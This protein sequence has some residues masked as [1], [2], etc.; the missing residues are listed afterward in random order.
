[1]TSMTGLDV[2]DTTVHK[3]NSW[4]KEIMDELGIDNH[5]QAYQALRGTSQT[6]RDRLPVEEATHLDA[7][8]PMLIS[9]IYYES[10]EPTDKPEK[11]R[12]KEEFLE[13][14]GEAFGWQSNIDPER[15]ACAVFNVLARRVSEGEIQDVT[16]ILPQELRSL[17]PG[18]V[19]R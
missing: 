19:R 6:L 8:L 14:V 13:R 10:W 15:A 18:E 17:W 9:G 4:L 12:S 3:T 2:F 1:M 7:Q 16:G 11:I 5:H